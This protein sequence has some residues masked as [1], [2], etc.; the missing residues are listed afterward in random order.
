MGGLT[1]ALAPEYSGNDSIGWTAQMLDV[2]TIAPPGVGF[3][4]MK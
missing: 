2:A 1:A 3:C 4:L